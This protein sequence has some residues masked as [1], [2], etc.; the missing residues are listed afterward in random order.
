MR[1]SRRAFLFYELSSFRYR[2]AGFIQPGNLGFGHPPSERA[3]VLLCLFGILGAGN[4]E[5]ALA[6]RPIQCHLC[7][8]FAAMILADLGHQ[9]DQWS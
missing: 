8:G 5:R 3:R 2:V 4:G 6:D 1:D 7:I 9:F